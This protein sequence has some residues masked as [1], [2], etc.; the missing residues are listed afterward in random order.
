MRLTNLEQKSIK[1]T[2]I[3]IFDSLDDYYRKFE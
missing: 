3:E 1:E 2:F